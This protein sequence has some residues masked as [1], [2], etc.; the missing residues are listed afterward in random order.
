[1]NSTVNAWPES[2]NIFDYG[3]AGTALVGT[4]KVSTIGFF[5]FSCIAIA[6]AVYYNP[7]SPA[8]MVP[9]GEGN[10]HILSW[11]QG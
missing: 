2:L 10:P 5:I 3:P 11:H 1:M 8:W 6:P 4:G 7:D 9:V